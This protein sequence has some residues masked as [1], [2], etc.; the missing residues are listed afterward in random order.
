MRILL[1]DAS[2]LTARQA[3][4]CL[5]RAGHQVEALSPG[6]LCLCGFTRHVTRLH[7]VPGYGDDPL[8]WLDAALAVCVSGG[9]TV[10]L[11]T[12]EQVAALSHS[13][14]R[15]RAAG[16]ATAVPPFAALRAVQDKLSAS[17]TLL[18][19]GIGQ[20]RTD[21]VQSADQL[22]GWQSVPVFV[23]A[24]VGTASA[25]VRHVSSADA[26]R[27]CADDLESAGEFTS[28]GVIV[29]QPVAGPLAMIQSVWASGTMVAAHACLR[30][31]EGASGGAS[32]KRSLDDTS[33]V[34]ARIEL[35]GRALHWHGA[36]S[37]DAVLT[38]DGPMFID[39]NPRLVEPGNALAAGVDLTGALVEVACGR[40]PAA[41]PAG[42]PGV[43]THQ[44][45]LAVLGAA[46]AGQGRRGVATE[47]RAALTCSGSYAGSTEELTPLGGDLRGGAPV[48]LAAAAA[49]VHPRLSQG[50]AAR[51]VASYAL[52]RRGWDMLT[53][54]PPVP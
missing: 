31:R 30:V 51:S 8:G 18:A 24:G 2:S 52:T 35:L 15:L 38:D 27:R 13:A 41:R 43:A 1:S 25:G 44:L 50:L 10:L 34:L 6:R 16:V 21:F 39:I 33:E 46:A 11:P 26:L 19:L 4:R 48:A 5:A 14:G 12:Q 37:A 20:P 36:L 32:H 3:A 17:G 23:K 47:L 42:Q 45:L 53:A 7:R 9:F 22:R 29:Q 54:T 28:G 40:E 49:L